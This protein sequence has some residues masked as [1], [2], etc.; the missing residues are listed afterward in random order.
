V[1]IFLILLSVIIMAGYYVISSPSVRITKHETEYAIQR[2]DLR[3][4]AECVVSSQNA[5]MYGEE[6]VDVCTERFDIVSQ[7]VCMNN[8]YSVVPCESENTKAPDFNFIITTSY[9]LPEKDYN[10][11]LEILEK[12]YPDVGTFGIFLNPDLMSAGS[13]SNRKI[14][15]NIINTANLQTGQLVYIMQYK[16]PEETIDYPVVDGSTIICP[17]GTMKTY[18]F[19]R[20]QCIEYNYK[21]SCTGDT[22][23]D[24]DLMDC[25]EDETRKPLCS[26]NQTAVLIDDIWECV[27][28]FS[29]KTCPGGMIARLN[30]NSLEWECVEDPNKTKKS[31]KCENISNLPP[32]FGGVGATLRVRSVSCTDCETPVVDEET[33]ET[34][35]I[36]DPAKLKDKKCYNGDIEECS[37]PTRGIYF[38]FSHKSRI[39]GIAALENTTVILDRNHNQNRMFNCIDCGDGII[40][41]ENSKPPYT[42]VCK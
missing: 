12:Y 13:I 33:C 4:I 9:P 27:D 34:Y 32:S 16:I 41:T 30:Y 24:S 3:S 6:F 26:N 38:G 5:A 2:A 1:N 17:S 7:Y 42:A 31:K 22:I 37:G 20:W 8:R 28:P 40:D 19:G 35:C 15:S 11:M 29:D 10:N 39:D 21:T 18:R 36:P 25:V 14:P 23:W